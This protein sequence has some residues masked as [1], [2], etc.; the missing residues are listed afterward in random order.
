MLL[1][2]QGSWFR[3]T[4]CLDG[5]FAEKKQKLTFSIPEKNAYHA[6]AP[7]KSEIPEKQSSLSVPIIFEQIA[8]NYVPSFSDR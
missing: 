7:L 5:F 8:T 6:A 3:K 1:T 2:F 4:S